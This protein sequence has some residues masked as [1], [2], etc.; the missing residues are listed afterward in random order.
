MPSLILSNHSY[1]DEIK[2]KLDVFSRIALLLNK[3]HIAWIL[4]GS[5]MLFFRG[6]VEDFDDIDLIV[7]VLDIARIKRLFQG[8]KRL[9]KKA[10]SAFKTK[11]FLVYSIDD[12]TVEIMADLVIVHNQKDYLCSYG[13]MQSELWMLEHHQIQL[14][15]LS[16]WLLYYRL[17]KREDKVALIT[18]HLLLH[19]K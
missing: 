17:M 8:E 7:D 11:H 1:K 3:H 12:V 15:T 5:C 4:G 16:D 6:L 13:D 2:H 9:Q 14:A 19:E 18:E 10:S